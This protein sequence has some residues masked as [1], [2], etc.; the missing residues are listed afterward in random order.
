M[1]FIPLF[2]QRDI[3]QRKLDFLHESKSYFKEFKEILEPDYKKY[4]KEVSTVDM[5][6]SLETAV[7]LRVMCYKLRPQRILDLGSGFSSFVFRSYAASQDKSIYICSVDDNLQ[8]LEKTRNYL[9]AYNLAAEKLISW[10]QIDK[11]RENSFDLVFHDL[12][13]MQTRTTTLQKVTRFVKP[14]TGYLLLDDIHKRDYRRY[15]FEVLKFY[16]LQDSNLK[17]YTLDS[18]GRYA[19]LFTNFG[20]SSQSYDPMSHT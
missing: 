19:W 1:R 9:L 5:A 10:D 16:E 12:G 15:S 4:V 3:L 8:W 17:S 20:K 6:V 7:F 2:L 14:R 18:F 11:E 13:N